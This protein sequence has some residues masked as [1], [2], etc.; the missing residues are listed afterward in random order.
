[1]TAPWGRGGAAL[2]QCYEKKRI[3][4]DAGSPCTGRIGKMEVHQIRRFEG[5][6]SQKKNPDAPPGE[7]EYIKA[8]ACQNKFILKKHEKKKGLSRGL[9]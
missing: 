8:K 1:V 5:E 9:K 3:G 2:I 4:R 7:G 6:R